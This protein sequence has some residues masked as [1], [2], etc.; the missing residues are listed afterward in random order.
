[1]AVALAR[2]GRSDQAWGLLAHTPDPTLRTYL[3]QYLG[4][5]GVDRG[6]VIGRLEVETDTS[7]RRALLLAL[8]S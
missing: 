4:E 7:A 8:E 5:L 2:M 1:V 6:E 3:I